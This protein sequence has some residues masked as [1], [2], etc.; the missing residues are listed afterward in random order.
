MTET[1]GLIEQYAQHLERKASGLVLRFAVLGALVGAALGGFPLFQGSNAI[2]PHHLGYATLLL[3]AAAGAY[4]GWSLGERRAVEPRFQAQL[5]LRQLQ[6]E[7]TL[8]RGAV[9]QPAAPAPVSPPAPA[10]APVVA[11]PA[12]PAAAPA[13]APAPV[14]APEPAPVLAP[15]P[16]PMPAAVR[17]P[18]PAPVPVAAPPAPPVVQ[19]APTPPPVAL[20]VAVPAEE[21]PA[22]PAA[23][24]PAPPRL[25]EPPLSSTGA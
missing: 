11:A 13:P 8:M 20:P 16:A 19:V 12:P 14:L 23:V 3:G 2:V 6:V 15:T 21:E 17:L 18:P 9:A 4:L 24:A 22:P 7:Q 25:V 10:P 1:T 5:A